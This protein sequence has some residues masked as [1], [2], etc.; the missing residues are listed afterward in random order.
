M[1]DLYVT[2]VQKMWRQWN[3]PGNK[4]CVFTFP[5]ECTTV[6]KA[7]RFDFF[8]GNFFSSNLQNVRRADY[9]DHLL[10]RIAEACDPATL[11]DAE[12]IAKEKQISVAVSSHYSLLLSLK[13]LFNIFRV[14]M[15]VA[16][17]CKN[18]W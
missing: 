3:S 12:D 2:H 14:K 17:L 4:L 11:I 8:L 1:K 6:M 5:Q 15:E 10:A 13:I 16:E 18:M 9:K 7:H